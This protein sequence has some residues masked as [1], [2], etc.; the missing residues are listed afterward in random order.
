MADRAAMLAELGQE[1]ATCQRC[2][3]AATRTHAVPGEG[4]VNAQIMFIGEGP[5]EQEDR[6]GRP[7]VG[8]AGQLLNQLL[9]RVGLQRSDIFITNIVK[10]RPPRNRDPQ[11]AE[12]AACRPYLDAQIA[13]L[14]PR[15]ICLLGKP[16]T[17]AL[18]APGASMGKVHGV[19]QEVDGIIYVPLYHPAAALHQP[20]LEA[21]L[22]EDMERLKQFLAS[23]I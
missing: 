9:T 18:L 6:S 22:V 15:V 5:G 16:A 19:P 13:L 12:A 17:H 8:A 10:C 20:S 14:T 11:P 1:I 2:A 4:P 23:A 7:F 3:L 21:V